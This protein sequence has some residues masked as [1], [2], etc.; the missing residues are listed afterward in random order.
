MVI[1]HFTPLLNLNKIVLD[2]GIHFKARHYSAWGKQDYGWTK[3]F[4]KPN[5]YEYM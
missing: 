5:N 3:D 4:V 2:V 1:Y